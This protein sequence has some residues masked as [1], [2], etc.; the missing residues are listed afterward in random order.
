MAVLHVR[1]IP[2]RLYRQVQKM[3]EAQGRSLSAQIIAILEIAVQQQE[4]RSRFARMM[5]DIRRDIW[6]PPPG[7][8]DATALLREVRE[9]RDAEMYSPTEPAP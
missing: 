1:E 5:G 7:T 3:A 6:T 9:E 8:P 4:A 2:D